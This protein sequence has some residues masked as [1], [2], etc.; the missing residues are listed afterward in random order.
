MVLHSCEVGGAVSAPLRDRHDLGRRLARAVPGDVA[1]PR[2]ILVVDVAVAADA[3]VALAAAVAAGTE[4]A[5]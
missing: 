2:G 5:P 3:A 4:P 1:R